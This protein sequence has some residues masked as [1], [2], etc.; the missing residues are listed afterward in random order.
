MNEKAPAGVF[1]LPN[2]KLMSIKNY[3]EYFLLESSPMA[4]VS[5]LLISC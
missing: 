2:R 3:Y 1:L 5:E 4:E